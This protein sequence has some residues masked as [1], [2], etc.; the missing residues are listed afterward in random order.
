MTAFS[1]RLTNGANAVSKLHAVT[2]NATWK[3]IVDH[4]I[5]AITNGVHTARPGSV[6]RSRSSSRAIWMPT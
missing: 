2:A 3:D 1:L 4:E 5:L 6:R